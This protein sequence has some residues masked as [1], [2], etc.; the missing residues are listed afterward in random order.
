MSSGQ[1]KTSQTNCFPFSKVSNSICKYASQTVR[2][3]ADDVSFKNS[4]DLII[5]FSSSFLYKSRK[6][7]SGHFDILKASL[8]KQGVHS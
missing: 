4:P 6:L 3:T 8:T 1:D 7:S 2:C 5:Q